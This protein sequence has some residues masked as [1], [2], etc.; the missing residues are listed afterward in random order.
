MSTLGSLIALLGQNDIQPYNA[1]ELTANRIQSGNLQ[2]QTALLALNEQK[3]QEAAQAAFLAALQQHPELVLGPQSTLGALAPGMGAPAGGGPGPFTQQPFGPGGIGAP[4]TVAAP[5]DL[6]QFATGMPP[7]GGMPG[8]APPSPLAALAPQVDP[9]RQL[10]QQ[11]PRAGLLL[12]QRMQQSQDV[13]TKMQEQQLSMR[14]KVTEYLAKQVQGIGSQ[15]QLE[16]V[17]QD[18][19]R[20][21]PAVAARLPQFYSKAAMQ[22]LIDMGQTA[23]ENAQ[24]AKALADAQKAQQQAQTEQ[25]TREVMLPKLMEPGSPS[26][27]E[28]PAGPTGRQTAAPAEVETAVQEAVRLYP[29]VRP[30]LVRAII[31]TES[32]FDPRAVSK[33]G[34]KGVMQLMD[35]TGRAMGVDDPFDTRQNVRGGVRYFAQLLTKYGGDEAKALAAYNAGPGAVDK[36]GGDL[37]ALPQETQAYVP[38]VLQ[39]AQVGATARGPATG[40][41]VQRIQAQIADLEGKV[42]LASLTP[43]MNVYADNLSKQLDRLYKE[44]DRLEEIPRA[45]EKETA[46][47]PLK[48]AQQEALGVGA[49]KLKQQAT[50]NRTLVQEVGEDKAAQYRDRTTGMPVDPGQ[51]YGDVIQ[52]TSGKTPTTIPL[53]A[54]QTESLDKLQ[55]TM[56]VLQELRSALERVYGP[57]G[58]FENLS[59]NDRAAAALK[60]GWARFAQTNPD[61]ALYGRLIE[62]NVDLIRRSLQGQVGTQTEQD[63]VRGTGAFARVTGIPDSQDVA[64]KLMDAFNGMVRGNMRTLL[65][66]PHFSHETLAPMVS[67][68]KK[69]EQ[70]IQ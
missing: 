56:P 47:Q 17:R 9:L 32:N 24:T 12:Q 53:S 66:N 48:V 30:E 18:L 61:L 70:V 55:S 36:A 3:R 10:M 34:A 4:Q 6:S 45:V 51:R 29:Q 19:Q 57:G 59:P 52:Q 1:Q 31:A 43:G 64:Y 28:T 15:E 39:R 20:W 41:Q 42:K 54:K 37:T 27:G 40:P 62:S 22:P 46:L 14:L 60:G 25:Y 23:L 69:F 26:G 68:V 58:I 2:N 13:Q 5:P 65:R 49:E 33:R 7:G 67:N 16:A 21:N 38:K 50:M 35:D 8:G 44:R 63:A 11:D